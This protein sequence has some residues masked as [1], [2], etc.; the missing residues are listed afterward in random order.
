M[1][2]RRG[3]DLQASSLMTVLC[4]VWGLQQIVLKIAATDISPLM[5]I[6]L[7]CGL[8][9]LLVVPLL[10]RQRVQQLFHY[11]YVVPGIWLAFLFS[12]EFYLV[13]EALRYTSAAHTVVLLYTAP[14][15]VALG[16][17][18]KVKAEKLNHLQWFGILF[19]FFG[20]AYTF[21]VRDQ[22]QS[23]LNHILWGDFLALMAGMMWALTTI[24]LE[25]S[26]LS[27]APPT[28]T[29]FYQ[30]LGGFIFLLPLAF[31]TGQA[32]V[33]WSKLA[34]LS[35][36]FHAVVMSFLSLLLWF[37]LLRTY[38]ANGLGVFSFLTPMFGMLFG[39]WL[40]DEEIETSF[41]VG[42]CMVLAGIMIVSLHRYLRI[43]LDRISARIGAFH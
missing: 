1:G 31:W 6:A 36:T 28:Q 27:E 33:R 12:A 18:W 9:T 23:Q 3:L 41:L 35:L 14:I 39:V 22:A 16:L 10:Y 4:L 37:W 38:L 26:T 21:L 20:I 42:S 13:A 5:Q 32:D 24:S 34:F 40:L 11:R 19:A 29:L 30:L 7:R 2:E 17:H 25:F 8:A 15:F 43:Y